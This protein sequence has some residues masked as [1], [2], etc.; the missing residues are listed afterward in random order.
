MWG[1]LC[2]TRGLAE[3][4][5]CFC[6]STQFLRPSFILGIDPRCRVSLGPSFYSEGAARSMSSECSHAT[7][8]PTSRLYRY[9]VH[10]PKHS[11]DHSNIY[12]ASSCLICAYFVKGQYRMVPLYILE[13]QEQKFQKKW[14]TYVNLVHLWYRLSSRNFTYF[15]I[16]QR[17]VN[18]FYSDNDK[19]IVFHIP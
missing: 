10:T 6:V 12:Q 7:Q 16:S 15:I 11:K 9:T 14:L 1:Q 2:S 18:Y 4:D 8:R 13:V 17:L 5:M 19:I 3:L